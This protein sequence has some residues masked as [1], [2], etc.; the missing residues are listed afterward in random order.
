LADVVTIPQNLFYIIIALIVVVGVI[1][2][3]MQWRRVRE[4]QSNINF[5]EKQAELR[6]IELV[7]KDLE[8]KRLS[9]NVFPLPKEQQERLSEIRKTTTELMHQSGYLHSEINERVTHLEARTEFLKL[10]KLLQDIEGKEKELDKRTKGSRKT[11]D[12]KTKKSGK[13]ENTSSLGKLKGTFKR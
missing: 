8:S 10:Q 1:V 2:A 11:T 3:L 13:T 5:L 4:S 7:E 6:K 9:E 12:K